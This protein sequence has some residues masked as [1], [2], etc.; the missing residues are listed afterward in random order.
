MSTGWNLFKLSNFFPHLQHY[1]IHAAHF[2][3]V[4]SFQL[5]D[6][7]IKLPVERR[8]ARDKPD[9]VTILIEISNTLLYS[10]HVEKVALWQ[11]YLEHILS[12]NQQLFT[13]CHFN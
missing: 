10:G 2:L 5:V 13:L 1:I 6:R 8:G 4:F 3:K 12:K 9:S 11:L 7:I